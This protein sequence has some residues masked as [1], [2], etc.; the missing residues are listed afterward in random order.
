VANTLLPIG[1]V[2]TVEAYDSDLRSS[3]LITASNITPQE[4]FTFSVAGV[5]NGTFSDILKPSK[6]L[7]S[8]DVNWSEKGITTSY[9]YQTRP[10]LPP[11]RDFVFS[12]IYPTFI[13]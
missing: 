9:I 7:V 10:L 6:G 4:S 5:L 8:F 11:K 1:G 12:R 13:K 3:A 2:K